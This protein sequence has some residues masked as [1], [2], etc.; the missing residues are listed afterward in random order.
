LGIYEGFGVYIF[1]FLKSSIKARLKII[2]KALKEKLK[3]CPEI[4][5]C[6]ECQVILR[7]DL[8]LFL[9]KFRIEKEILKRKQTNRRSL[10]NF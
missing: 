6:G 9:K 5:E 4:N 7:I 8:G 10:Q 3:M 2:W 1:N